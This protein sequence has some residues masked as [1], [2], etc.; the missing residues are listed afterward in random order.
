MKK[1]FKLATVVLTLV[2]L[3]NLSPVKAEAATK[4]VVRVSQYRVT[5]YVGGQ[6]Q[7]KQTGSAKTYSWWS[8][9]QKVASVSSK[10]VIKAKR[11]GTATVVLK[12]GNKKSRC[13]VTVKA[14]LS[15]KQVVNKM[16]SQVKNYKNMTVSVYMDEMKYSNLFMKMAM[17]RKDQIQYMDFFGITMYTT[18]KKNYWRDNKTKKWY[19]EKNTEGVAEEDF[20]PD[21][22]AVSSKAKYK[23]L[24]DKTFNKVKCAV[25]QVEEDGIKT[26]YYFDLKDYS[27]IGGETEEIDGATA[28]YKFDF[29]TT[30]KVPASVTKNAKYK[31]FNPFE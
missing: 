9:N 23:L 19:Y 25:L 20:E 4:P 21:D 13:I 26:F 6:T 11:Q 7:I 1:I 28:I 27:L 17:N 5:L 8:D 30:V 12:S 31:E 14:K 16:N 29:K 22:V 10:G 24:A 3:L 18:P 2:L 15:A